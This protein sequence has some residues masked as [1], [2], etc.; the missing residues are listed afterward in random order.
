V[1][2]E[3]SGPALPDHPGDAEWIAGYDQGVNDTRDAAYALGYAAGKEA[4][5]RGAFLTVAAILRVTGTVSVP[6]RYLVEASAASL[7]T[8]DDLAADRVVYRSISADPSLP[9]PDSKS[10]E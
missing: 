4:A 5:E 3:T 9:S 1:T 7:T 10:S 2:D 8:W 6:R